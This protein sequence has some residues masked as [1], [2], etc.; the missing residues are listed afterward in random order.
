MLRF[1]KTKVVKENF[2]SVEKTIKTWKVYV[3]NI[4]ISKSIRTKK[5]FKSLMGC[6]DNG[7]RPVVLIMSRNCSCI[8]TF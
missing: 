2:C 1:C 5:G 4:E 7:I 8:R 6:L 3:N